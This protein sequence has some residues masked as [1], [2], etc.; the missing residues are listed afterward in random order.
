MSQIHQ[1]FESDIIINS[2]A[3][4]AISPDGLLCQCREHKVWHGSRSNQGV[5][6]GKHY[7]EATVTDEGLC[8]VGWSTAKATLELGK[9]CACLVLSCKVIMLNIHHSSGKDKHGYGF[10]GTAKKSNASQFDDYGEVRRARQ[11][12]DVQS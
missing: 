9:C 11:H 1:V 2:I 5:E 3:H 6:S 4:V 10:G 7:F 12:T 8:R